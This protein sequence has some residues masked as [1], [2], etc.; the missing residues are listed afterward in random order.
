MIHFGMSMWQSR[1]LRQRRLNLQLPVLGKSGSDSMM[2][3]SSPE[4]LSYRKF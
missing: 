3:I 2:P 4:Y 1:N